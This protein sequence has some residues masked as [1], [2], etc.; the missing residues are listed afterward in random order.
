[1]YRVN[2]GIFDFRI[3]YLFFIIFLIW[4]L[5]VYITN[6]TIFN[7]SY[8]EDILRIN[9]GNFFTKNSLINTILRVQMFRI[10]F[11]P[12]LIVL[13]ILIISSAFYLYNSFFLRQ[14]NFKNIVRVVLLSE[15]V[16]IV[17]EIFWILNFWNIERA[18]VPFFQAFAP[19]GIYR[20]FD[21]DLVP[22]NLFFAIHNINLF[23]VF[24]IFSLAFGF[25]TIEGTIYIKSLSSSLFIYVSILF[26]WIALITLIQI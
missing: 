24:Y 10:V 1:M 17:N 5:L 26:F 14:V 9:E 2:P 8:Y 13:K 15:I 4:S 22:Q 6:C 19:L 18:S 25:S 21:L 23:Q 20:F 16:W 11:Y 12:T 7:T 3:R